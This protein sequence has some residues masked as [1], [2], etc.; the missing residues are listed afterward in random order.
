MILAQLKVLLRPRA[1]ALLILYLQWQTA[2]VGID[3]ILALYFAT[4]HRLIGL[5]LK[6]PAQLVHKLLLIAIR[7]LH[8]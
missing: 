8:W 5:S 2:K 6:L 7:L 4:L 1:T 3:D